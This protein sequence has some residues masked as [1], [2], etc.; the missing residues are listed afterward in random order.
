MAGHFIR[1]SGGRPKHRCEPPGDAGRRGAIWSCDCGRR[2]KRTRDVSIIDYGC[3]EWVRWRWPWPKDRQK[4][5]TERW[6][7]AKKGIRV[8][9]TKGLNDNFIPPQ[10]NLDRSEG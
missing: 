6:E 5:E 1:E 9:D 10:M 8:V 4:L 3:P 7:N 2:W